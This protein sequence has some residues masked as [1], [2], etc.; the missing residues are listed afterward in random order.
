MSRVLERLRSM[1]QDR[2][3]NNLPVNQDR[4]KQ[5]KSKEAEKRLRDAL[6]D[7]K[8]TVRVRR[9]DDEVRRFLA[10]ND[11]QQVVLF[12]T[13]RDICEFGIRAGEHRLCRHPSHEAANSGIA[14]CDEAIC[15]AI[16]LALKGA[17]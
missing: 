5:S 4:R 13:F 11:R 6:E 2:R 8:E 17:A 9:P 3:Q 16:G 15:P 1:I 12:S 10:S 14:R 7:F